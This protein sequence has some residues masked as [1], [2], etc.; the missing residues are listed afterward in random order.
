[1]FL[2]S[3]IQHSYLIDGMDA[4]IMFKVWKLH[5][6]QKQANTIHHIPNKEARLER[7]YQMY[8]TNRGQKRDG[9]ATT[10]SRIHSFTYTF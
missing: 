3:S 7:N 9:E 2:T 6:K 5:T 10:K 4:S 8:N 1:M